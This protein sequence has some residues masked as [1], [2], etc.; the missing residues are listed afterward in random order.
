VFLTTII[1]AVLS[2]VLFT[3]ALIQGQGS[4][5]E[6]LKIGWRMTIEALPLIILAFIAAGLLQTL[7]PRDIVSRWL[8]NESGIRG[9][10]VGS[11]AG[12]MTLGGPYVSYPIA[13][14]LYKSGAGIG[15]M[16]AFISGWSLWS[17]GR[18]PLEIGLMG[19]R[20]TIIRYASILF[21][22]PLAG[23]IA[24]YLAKIIR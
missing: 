11:F 18:L 7:I 5:L 10:L 9:L 4:H 2:L 22:P 14:G 21:L 6:G 15:T 8:G 23:V 1:M 3:V 17:F 12:A 24:S 19:W 16:V 13:A 20:F